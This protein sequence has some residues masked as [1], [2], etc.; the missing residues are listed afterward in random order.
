MKLLIVGANGALGR[1]TA[2]CA[3]RQGMLV[4]AVIHQ[5]RDCLPDGLG[6]VVPETELESLGPNSYAAVLITSGFIPYGRM[7]APDARLADVNIELPLRLSRAF[8]DAR[9]VY[10]SSVAVYGEPTEVL[11]ES[12]PFSGPSL[13]GLSKLAGEAVVHQHSSFAIVRFSSLYGVGMSGQTFLPRIVSVARAGGPIE[14]YGDGSRLQDYLHLSDAAALMVEAAKARDDRTYLGV[15][16]ESL[17]NL[18]A[19]NEI[20]SIFPDCQVTHVGRDDSPSYVFDAS[21]TRAALAFRP[22]MSFREG[23]RELAQHD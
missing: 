17:S 4:D 21:A 14:L 7:D 9:L 13:Y 19:A 10:A 16:G 11:S 23:I 3:L 5:R 18:D 20:A 2:E 1:R 15:F 22:Q 8:P 6:V 12:S